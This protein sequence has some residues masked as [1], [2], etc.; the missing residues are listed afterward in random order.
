MTTTA[1][2]LTLLF[3]TLPL[4]ACAARQ[5]DAAGGQQAAEQDGGRVT[6]PAPAPVS[7][8]VAA[9]AQPRTALPVQQPDA[10]AAQ[11]SGEPPRSRASAPAAAS[12]NAANTG[13]AAAAPLTGTPVQETPAARTGPGTAPASTAAASTVPATV[14]AT[15]PPAAATGPV[16]M[17]GATPTGSLLQTLF[18]LVAVLAVLA[19]LAWFLKRYGPKAGG[20]S[21]DL[22]IV[23]SLNLGGRERLLVVEVGSQW[24]VVGASPGRVN[25]LATMPKQEGMAPTAALAAHGPAANSFAD[26]LKQTI[27][28]RK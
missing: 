18:A 11:P 12:G 27:D 22:R 3:L 23:G 6:A 9:P 5:A 8:P 16:T 10:P 7:A 14:P 24:I 17:P 20:G 15:V 25:A 19:A 26:W 13:A 2:L 28:K 4:G 1:R 21:A